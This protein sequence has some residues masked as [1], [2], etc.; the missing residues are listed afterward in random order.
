MGVDQQGRAALVPSMAGQVDFAD[1]GGGQGV[2]IGG[3]VV[4]EVMGADEDV[5]DV[6]QQAAAGRPDQGGEEVGLVQIVAGQGD[7][8]LGVL[9]QNLAAQGVL[10]PADIAGDA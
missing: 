4:A 9:D 10:H 8:E 3:G 2:Q 6:D 5:I 1:H 7:V